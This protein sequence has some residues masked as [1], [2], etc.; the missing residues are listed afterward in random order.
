M[1][2]EKANRENATGAREQGDLWIETRR[3]NNTPFARNGIA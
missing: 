2:F 1:G 3:T